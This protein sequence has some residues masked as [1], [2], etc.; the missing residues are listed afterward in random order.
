MIY[1][2]FVFFAIAII[3][4][5]SSNEDML[6]PAKLYLVTFA[7]FHAGALYTNISLLA[8]GMIF[9]VLAV[10]FVLTFYEGQLAQHLPPMRKR[11]RLIDPSQTPDFSKALWVM[12]APAVLAQL[13]MIQ[14]FGGITGYI[15]SL[16]TRVVD[17]AGYGW[18]RTLINLIVPLNLIYFALGLQTRRD[19]RWWSLY[20]VHFLIVLALGALSGSRGGLLTVFVIQLLLFH[21]LRSPVKGRTAAILATSLVASAL[22]LGVVRNGVR[23]ED[24]ALV[25][26]TFNQQSE[27]SLSSFNSGVMA[28][29]I[30][31]E[32]P[33]MALAHGS[34]F[35]SVLTNAIPRAMWPGKPD[36]GGVFFTKNYTGDAW[37]G[38]SNLAPTFLGEFLINYGWAGGV[39]G[40]ALVYS[41]I[42][43][44]TVR[45]YRRIR[46]RL[47]GMLTPAMAVDT[48]VYL[49][50]AWAAVALMVGETTNVVVNTVFSQLLP[51]L[52]VRFYVGR[53]ERLSGFR[54]AM[55]ALP[56]RPQPRRTSAA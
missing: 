33:Y 50:L 35:V 56:P 49:V 47:Q 12:T 7:M 31:T 44:C 21:Y 51:I 22:V 43:I 27:A 45:Y 14:Q 32:T 53:V 30:I 54:D 24:G 25:F 17:W 23:F 15:D 37:L 18:A 52:A 4:A 16:G 8:A 48:V 34:T 6:S 11:W 42:M 1:V 55:V 2:V 26:G 28:M 46:M 5:V 36:P 39:I 13:F 41:L 40:F 10:G 19:R 29:K 38:F 3:V 9:L 20:L